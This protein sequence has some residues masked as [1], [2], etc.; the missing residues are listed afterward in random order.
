MVL[1]GQISSH[2]VTKPLNPR[3]NLTT[4]QLSMTESWFNSDGE[5]RDRKNKIPVEVVGRDA[6]M[7]AATAKLGSWVTIEGYIRSEQFKGQEIL[8]VRTFTITVWEAPGEKQDHADRGATAS[9][10]PERAVGQ[11]D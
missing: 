7:V 6:A 2:P 4:F 3:T 8:K 9:R 5:P 10:S 1:Q 11:G